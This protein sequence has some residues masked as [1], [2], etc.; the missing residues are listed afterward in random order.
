[1][2][3]TH[4]SSYLLIKCFNSQAV[5]CATQNFT[6][7]NTCSRRKKLRTTRKRKATAGARRLV[8]EV[9]KRQGKR[10]DSST[11]RLVPLSRAELIQL[12]VSSQFR[13]VLPEGL[14]FRREL[15]PNSDQLLSRLLLFTFQEQFGRP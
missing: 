9:K 5:F 13:N 7:Y 12:H 1:M 4:I 14:S 15:F 6:M 2:I 10:T 3:L 11:N 8:D